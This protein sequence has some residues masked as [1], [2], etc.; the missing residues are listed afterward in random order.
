[1][2]RDELSLICINIWLDLQY[3]YYK[4]PNS[5]LWEDIVDEMPVFTWKPESSTKAKISGTVFSMILFGI[6]SLSFNAH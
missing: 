3:K 1:M 6:I 4:D 2:S 5:T